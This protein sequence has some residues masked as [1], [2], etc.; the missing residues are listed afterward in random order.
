MH[1]CFNASSCGS[2]PV[3]FCM[4]HSGKVKLLFWVQWTIWYFPQQTISL[5]EPITWSKLINGGV[6]DNFLAIGFFWRVLNYVPI[7]CVKRQT[8][9]R[10]VRIQTMTGF[11]FKRCYISKKKHLYWTL[12]WLEIL[13]LALIKEKETEFGLTSTYF[14]FFVN[15]P[16]RHSFA[17]QFAKPRAWGKTQLLFR[18]VN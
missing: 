17:W 4:L 11:N 1:D 8:D 16:C 7:S 14:S 9:L 5:V 6:E 2:H 15:V 13:M 10:I 12:M 3:C 18:S